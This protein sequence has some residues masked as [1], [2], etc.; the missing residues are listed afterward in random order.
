MAPI[1]NVGKNCALAELMPSLSAASLAHTIARHPD[2]FAPKDRWAM[3]WYYPVLS[4][5]VCGEAG[6]TRLAERRHV[7]VMDGLGVRCVADRPWVTA[8]ET[9]ECV[10]AHLAVGEVGLAHELFRW[11]RHLRHHDGSYWTGKVY[12]EQKHFPG[13]ERST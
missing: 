13:N 5:V 9:C 2:A 3:D 11:A 4:G 1:M 8:A 7:F 6:R 12:P 10:M